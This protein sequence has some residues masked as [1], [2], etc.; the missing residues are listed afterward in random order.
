MG[1][2]LVNLLFGKKLKFFS[3]KIKNFDKKWAKMAFLFI[4]QWRNYRFLKILEIFWKMILRAIWAQ[5][6]PK[7]A[8]LIKIDGSKHRKTKILNKKNTICSYDFAKK[9]FFESNMISPRK[10]EKIRKF[11]IIFSKK[12]GFENCSYFDQNMHQRMRLKFAHQN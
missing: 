2:V 9:C 7:I 11:S 6:R 4:I 5:N 8:I 10:N 3:Q 1:S 12:I